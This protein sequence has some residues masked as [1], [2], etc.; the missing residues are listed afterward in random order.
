MTT[1]TVAR[2]GNRACIGAD[3]LASYGSTHERAEYV[4][5]H[6]KLV[7][8]EDT[9][10]AP[11]GP[12][13]AQLVLESYFAPAEPGAKPEGDEPLE[14]RRDFSSVRGVFETFTDMMGALKDDYFLIPKEDDR[15]PYESL[16]MEVMVAGPGGLFGVYP[17]RSVQEYTRFYAF[18]SGAEVALGAM[19]AIYDQLDDPEAIVRAGLEAAS[20][21]D[22]GTGAPF[23]IE[24]FSVNASAGS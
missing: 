22:D 18:G 6:S 17:L 15:D 13:S 3:S 9:F 12:A 10:L 7:R 2:K 21:F 20:V 19:H 8:V 23:T 11:T 14:A 5:N 16:Q 24:S 1:I 4:R